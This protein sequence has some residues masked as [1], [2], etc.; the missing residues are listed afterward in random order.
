LPASPRLSVFGTGPIS[1]ITKVDLGVEREQ[2][3]RARDMA[4]NSTHGVRIAYSAN[5]AFINK[6]TVDTAV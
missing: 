6:S 1:D 3:R 2:V 5:G 4:A